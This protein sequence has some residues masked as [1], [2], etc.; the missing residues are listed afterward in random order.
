M[1]MQHFIKLF[2]VLGLVDISTIKSKNSILHRKDELIIVFISCCNLGAERIADYIS[3][4]V[5]VCVTERDR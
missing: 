5:C 2:L 1:L 3:V 4:C